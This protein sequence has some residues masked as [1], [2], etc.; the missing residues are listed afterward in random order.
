MRKLEGKINLTLKSAQDR[1]EEKVYSYDTSYRE[2]EH[3]P[4]MHY[5]TGPHPDD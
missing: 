5:M 4:G 2:Q 3:A 1:K